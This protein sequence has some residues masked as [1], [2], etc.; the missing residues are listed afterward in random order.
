MGP[1][2]KERQ[3]FACRKMGDHQ[4]KREWWAKKSR[5]FL[6]RIDSWHKD[7]DDRKRCFSLHYIRVAHITQKHTITTACTA[8]ET[9]GPVKDISY[10]NTF[11]QLFSI[12]SIIVG[13]L[14]RL[15][16]AFVI[17]ITTAVII[18]LH[19]HRQ[20]RVTQACIFMH[21]VNEA[22]LELN[23]L[24]LAVVFRFFFFLFFSWKQIHRCRTFIS[25]RASV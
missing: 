11:S 21:V 23:G 7:G 9:H 18:I 2:Q 3:I 20:Y 19:V 8:K 24:V 1:P 10:T 14:D 4:V 13:L 17:I 6:R 16:I 22:H 15:T 25:A 12:S 5:Q